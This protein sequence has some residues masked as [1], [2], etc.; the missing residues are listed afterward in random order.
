MER[1]TILLTATS[2]TAIIMAYNLYRQKIGKK[3]GFLGAILNP[4]LVR[5]TDAHGSGCFG[6][7]RSGHTHQG[8]D[9]VCAQG[10]EVLAPF[11]GVLNRYAN[12]YPNS[13]AWKGAELKNTDGTLWVKL[14]YF[15][16]SIAPGTIIQRGQVI[17]H[18]QKISDKY[19]DITDH[20]HMEVRRTATGT[21]I[22]PTTFFTEIV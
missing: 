14:F 17:G 2:L 21:P 18:A 7:S 15:T 1:R 22:D 11:D 8:T 20:V 10:Q 4:L 6:A 19:P 12:P 9:F 16:P 5:G 3:D 13:P